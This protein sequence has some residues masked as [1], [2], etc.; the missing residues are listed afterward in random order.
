MLTDSNAFLL[1]DFRNPI[2]ACDSNK[3]MQQVWLVICAC[4]TPCNYLHHNC[5]LKWSCAN[6]FGTTLLCHTL[7]HFVTYSWVIINSL[8]YNCFLQCVWRKPTTR[9]T[10]ITIAHMLQTWLKPSTASSRNPRYVLYVTKW[11]NDPCCL[12]VSYKNNVY[13]YNS[14]PHIPLLV[15]MIELHR[16]LYKHEQTMQLTSLCMICIVCIVHLVVVYVTPE[17]EH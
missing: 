11:I 8:L 2:H 17:P 10:T 1:R 6:S 7:W 16:P 4:F 14:N 5:K 15:N 9:K 12:R 3:H 13:H